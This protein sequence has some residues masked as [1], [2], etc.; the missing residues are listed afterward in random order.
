VSSVAS[1]VGRGW[2]ALSSRFGSRVVT[3]SAAAAGLV[4]AV[5][6]FSRLHL[7]AFVVAGINDGAIYSLAAL[8]LVL[9]FKTSGIFNFAIGA[10]AAASAYVF[11]SFRDQAHL[12]WPVAALLA[13]VAV[14][15]FGSLVLERAAFW[16]T[17]AP[18]V[19]KVVAT[20]GLLVLLQSLLTGVYG[21]ATIEFRAFLPSA[22]VRIGSVNVSVSQFITVALALGATAGLYVYFRRARLG[23]AMQAVVEDSRLLSLE[24]TSPAS[25]R[26]VAWAIG[27]CFVSISGMLIAPELGIDVN[28]MLLIYIAAFGAGALASFTSLPGAFAAAMAIGIAMNVMDD[29]LASNSDQVVAGLYEQVPFIVLVAALLL[30]PRRRLI[31]RGAARARRFAP[32][33]AVPRWLTV[34]VTVAGLVLAVTLPYMVGGAYVSQYT[35]GL[36]FAIILG[37]LALLLWTSGQI[38]LCHMAFA[39]VGATTFS[40]AQSA[41]FPWFAAL[42]AGGLVALPVGAIIA[43]PSFRLAGIYLAVAT[44]GGGLLFQNLIFKTWLMFG[45]GYALAARRPSFAQTDRA[46]YYVVLAVAI[47][48]A[49]IVVGVRRSRLGRLMGGLADSPLALDAHGA[50]TRIVRLYVFCVSAFV[51]AIGG[52]ALAAVTQ[53]VNGSPTSPYGYFNSVVLVAVLAFSGR[54][55]LWS[56]VVAAFVLEVLKVYKPF[57]EASFVKFQ[58]VGFGLLALGVAIAPA[59]TGSWSARRAAERSGAPDRLQAR[60]A[61]PPQAEVLV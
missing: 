3:A 30:V 18:P 38:S 48:C 45:T 25:V 12:A 41:G 20:I 5:A 44:F 24:G 4:V 55:A 8:G 14:G 54:R 9:T 10:Q 47:A 23:V 7:W 49:G 1:P 61:A 57:S 27:S 40:H 11:H 26:R 16:L 2:A 13:L 28:I 35:T 42:L 39:A 19:M 31:E 36:A 51:A 37:S 46:Y 6:V 22:G 50:D 60:V 33:P 17:E 56:P 52:A 43:I 29:K 53:S 34:P 58:G 21:S 15:L 32:V 59:V